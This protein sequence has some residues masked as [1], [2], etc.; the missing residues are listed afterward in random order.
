MVQTIPNLTKKDRVLLVDGD[1]YN[2]GD[3]TTTIPNLAILKTAGYCLTNGISYGLNISDPT[4]VWASSV[5][6][7]NA[8]NLTGLSTLY[9][10][11][12]IILG[13]VGVSLH[14]ELP[15]AIEHS[16][17]DYPLY[18]INYSMIYTSRGCPNGC[19]FCRVPKK[20]GAIRDNAPITEAWDP[21]HKRLML[22]DNNFLASPK[23][24][25]NLDFIRNNGLR[26]NF[27]QGLD[28]RKVDEDAAARLAE[29]KFSNHNWTGRY[30]TFAWDFPNIEPAVRKG[31]D[32]LNAAGIKRRNLVFFVLVGY[33]TTFEQDYYR[34][35][36][37]K[38]L[39]IDPF[40]MIYDNKGTDLNRH[41]ARFI[42]K[43]LYRTRTFA[44]YR[45]LNPVERMQVNAVINSYEAMA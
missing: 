19:G 17:P 36:V 1:R 29:V 9:P 31:I 27:N 12:K 45:A 39:G 10:E 44:E 43:R 33:N 6:E 37:L 20:E 8:P 42:N 3:K 2:K 16:M 26:V 40:I 25:E 41:F 22:L 18:G 32:Y 11:A 15:Y 34:F 4:V 30:L 35:A 13:G 38:S 28:I 7:W 23:W 14:N 24:K 5:F 21:S